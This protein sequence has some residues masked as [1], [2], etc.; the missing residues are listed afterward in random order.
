MQWNIIN[1]RIEKYLSILWCIKCDLITWLTIHTLVGLMA[2]WKSVANA[3]AN[4]GNDQNMVYALHHVFLIKF[5][6]FFARI[7]M[8]W[9]S[10]TK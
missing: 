4:N 3:N 10:S 7:L 8:R 1:H 5:Y 9:E 2:T 6:I